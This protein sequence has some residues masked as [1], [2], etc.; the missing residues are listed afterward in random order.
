MLTYKLKPDNLYSFVV[1]FINYFT[2]ANGGIILLALRNTKRE[3]KGE[4]LLEHFSYRMK[5]EM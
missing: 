1:S 4:N 3:D 5:L 2:D